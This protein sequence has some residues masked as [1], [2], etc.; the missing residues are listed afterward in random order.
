MMSMRR[1]PLAGRVE[2]G[3]QRLAAALDD[4]LLEPLL[5]RVAERLPPS[6]ISAFLSA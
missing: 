1:V 3:D 4:R 5:D 2:V 6:S